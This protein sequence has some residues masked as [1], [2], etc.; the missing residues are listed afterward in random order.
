MMQTVL[1]IANTRCEEWALFA[2]P[3]ENVADRFDSI[4]TRH[5]GRALHHRTDMEQRRSRRLGRELINQ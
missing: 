3:I 1:D 4:W 2:I 5:F